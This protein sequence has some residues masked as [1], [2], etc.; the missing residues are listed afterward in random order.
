[1]K[2]LALEARRIK[3]RVIIHDH[4]LDRKQQSLRV[5]GKGADG[6]D[7]ASG[8]VAQLTASLPPIVALRTSFQSTTNEQ[9]SDVWL[10]SLKF[11][12]H[13]FFLSQSHPLE[14]I[15]YPYHDDTQDAAL[16]AMCRQLPTRGWKQ[17][18]QEGDAKERA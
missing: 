3:R 10:L 12:L 15:A 1:M 16:H 7:E 6:R 18:A 9:A 11:K 13:A 5:K 14:G 8:K 4:D 17:G 2:E